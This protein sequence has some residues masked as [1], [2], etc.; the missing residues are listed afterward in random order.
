MIDRI[1]RTAIIG[2]L[3]LG[4]A[5]SQPVPGNAQAYPFT[6]PDLARQACERL[7]DLHLPKVQ[8]TS[9]TLMPAGAFPEA[10]P[11]VAGT[12]AVALTAHCEVKAVARPASDSEIGIEIWLPAEH[13]N[14]KYEQTGNGGWAG[15]IHRRPLAAAVRRGYA[16]AAT[17]D[18]H[19]GGIGDDG[20]G[21]RSAGFAIGHPEKLIDYGYRALAETRAAAL[22]AIKAFYGRD[23]AWSYFV[24][25]S[26]GGREAL[27]VAQRFPKAFDGIL[28][29]D[30]GNNW[31]RWAAGLV[32]NRQAQLAESPGAIP[33]AKRALIQNAAVAACDAIDGVKDGL[34]SDPRFCRFDPAVLACT[35]ADTPG[36]LTTSQVATLRSIYDGPRNPRT[37]HQIY[38]G[39]PPGIENAPGSSLITPSRQGEFSF[40]DTY[41]GQAVFEQMDWDFRALDFDKDI[42]LSD[43]KASPVVDAVNPDL[44]AFRAHGGKLI[45]YHGWSDALMPAGGSI[46]YYENVSAFMREYGG[47][48]PVDNFYRLFMI[49]GMGHCYGGAGPTSISPTDDADATDPKHDLMLALEQ[50]VEKGVAP[51]M[52]IGSG[53]APNDPATTMSRPLCPYPQ[54]ARYKGTGDINDA[55][56]FECATPPARP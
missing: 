44:R 15:A 30:P 18:G 51:Q 36:C 10:E 34:I 55:R 4:A 47:S 49:P 32:W 37:V 11:T 1:R 29:G 54:A 24:G 12:V 33:I 5:A 19:Q 20:T 52:F 6:Q 43:R 40:G 9:A 3:S 16:A 22:A 25:C 13:W 42:A 39:F 50:W 26:D 23:A 7:N 35:G 28:A 2:A 31:S 56:R 48:G 46:A 21:T 17:D 8:I 27:M 38:P 53:K 45:Q 41:F 14:G